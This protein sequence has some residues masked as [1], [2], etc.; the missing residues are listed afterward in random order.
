MKRAIIYGSALASVTVEKFG[1][2]SLNELT[3]ERLDERLKRFQD[4]ISFEMK[5]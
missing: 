3:K 2:D 5:L 1:T 4:L